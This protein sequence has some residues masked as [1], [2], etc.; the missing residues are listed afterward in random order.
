[1]EKASM[2][3]NW[4][5]SVRDSGEKTYSRKAEIAGKREKLSVINRKKEVGC[6]IMVI[7]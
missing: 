7:S 6:A 4:Q 2:H 3:S 1:M 5:C